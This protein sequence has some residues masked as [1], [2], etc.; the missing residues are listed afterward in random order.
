MKSRSSDDCFILK[1]ELRPRFASYVF[2][3][4]TFQ[5]PEVAGL[6]LTSRQASRVDDHAS[7]I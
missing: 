4:E 3:S 7:R 1:S 5:R 6:C 2:A